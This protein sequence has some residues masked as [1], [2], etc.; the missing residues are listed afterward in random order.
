[1]KYEDA[2]T[3]V[4]RE[5][6]K[7]RR[8]RWIGVALLAVLGLVG[9]SLY[10]QIGIIN[11]PVDYANDEDHFKYG[12]IGS[13]V[14]GIPYWIW[15]TMPDVC[16]SQLPG[17]YASLGV[18]QEPGKDTPIGFSK[19][20]VGPVD[21]VGP[22]CSLCHTASVRSAATAEPQI[23][24]TA[25]ANQ[26]NLMGYFQFL[27]ACGRDP[28]FT[29]DNIMAA[30][31]KRTRLRLADR[32]AYRISVKEVR[33]GLLER[34]PLFDSIAADRP[35]WGP[36]RV[37]TFN[38]YK[39]LVFHLDMSKDKSI[40]TADFMSIWNQAPREGIWLHWDG[41]ND[42]VDERNLSAAM[43]A[44]AT[45]DTLD[46]QRILRIKRWILTKAPPPYPFPID[47][48]KAVAGKPVYDRYCAACHDIGA[49]YFG[50]V[51][52]LSELGT[53]PERKNSFD[54][55]MAERMNTIG[56]AEPW[57]FTRFRPTDG[58]ANH[59]LDGIWLRAPYLHNGSVPNLRDL[60]NPV[61]ERPVNFYRGNDVYD[62]HNVGFVSSEAQGNGRT[63]YRFD[64]RDR[65]NGNQGHLYGV[66][67]SPQD[68]NAL[69]EYLK[70][71]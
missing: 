16:P 34:A 53:D 55:A 29:A 59:P 17:G 67:L 10:R 46:F 14:K 25:P 50:G 47:Y 2:S 52:P 15:K 24:L 12:S 23:Y 39:V 5:S 58:Y 3:A 18:I 64:T 30:I 56:G 19:R 43:G 49:R 22:N 7:R 70:T 32:L 20:R 4:N 9:Y 11:V 40:G 27:F 63:F 54:A 41:N 37:D 61:N 42:S 45:P 28:N 33:K 65:G 44:G 35:P 69:L 71:L 48:A 6:L 62:Q 57:H 1:M 38:P 31:D 21:L 51:T 68:K 36:G 13:D 8:R 60:L 26:L 66:G